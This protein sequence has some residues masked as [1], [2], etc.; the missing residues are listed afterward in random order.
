M[1]LFMACLGI[2]VDKR[3]ISVRMISN[4]DEI[5][6]PKLAVTIKTLYWPNKFA[7]PH[8]Q[9]YWASGLCPSPGTLVTEVSCSYA[10]RPEL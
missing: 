4:Q 10:H 1:E 6:T 5:Q 2:C 3:G 7:T 9:N 8:V